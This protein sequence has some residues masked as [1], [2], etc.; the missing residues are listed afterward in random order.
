MDKSI[1][2]PPRKERPAAYAIPYSKKALERDLGRVQ[3]AWDDCQGDRRRDAVYGYLKAV[4]DL[5]N[6]WSAEGC[7]VDRTRQALRLRGLLPCGRETSTP[8]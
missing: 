2:P 5:A 4:Y 8:R 7:Q 3:E 6:W 1:R